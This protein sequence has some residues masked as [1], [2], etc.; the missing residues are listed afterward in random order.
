M[1]D[2][3]DSLEWNNLDTVKLN[4]FWVK[5]V[6]E[7]VNDH[8]MNSEYAHYIRIS[9]KKGMNRYQWFKKKSDAPEFLYI[10]K[11][12]YACRL[13]FNRKTGDFDEIPDAELTGYWKLKNDSLMMINN[14][15]Y[16]IKR[17]GNIHPVAIQITDLKTGN[18]LK[19]RDSSFPPA[20][21]NEYYINWTEENDK[22]HHKK[23]GFG[24]KQSPLLQGYDYKLWRKGEDFYGCRPVNKGMEFMYE[25]IDY[26]NRYYY[27]CEFMYF[28]KYGRYAGLYLFGDEWRMRGYEELFCMGLLDCDV[29]ITCGWQPV[30][31][32]S[33]RYVYL[34]FNE[35]VK[36]SYS[37][38]DTLHLHNLK[39]NEELRYIAVNLPPKNKRG[40]FKN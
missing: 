27:Y 23:W 37:N 14:N 39:T 9:K 31:N 18:K 8:D 34:N 13:V 38:K 40:K 33:I 15:R 1:D 25:D 16:S 12:R 20:L 28:D 19:I 3:S 24:I 4:S 7:Y 35:T 26:I 29:V 11:D 21:N 17:I 10:D 5:D 32:D 30:G 6:D 2:G 36:I 22:A